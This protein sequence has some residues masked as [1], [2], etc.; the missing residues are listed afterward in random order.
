M[1]NIPHGVLNGTY[2]CVRHRAVACQ[3][4]KFHGV[5]ITP[6]V[7]FNNAHQGRFADDAGGRF[8]ADVAQFLNQRPRTQAP[9]FLV[10]GEGKM[11]RLGKGKGSIVFGHGQAGCNEPLH[12][13]GAAAKQPALVLVHAERVVMSSPGL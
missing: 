10:M 3:T 8:H 7:T 5:F 11:H 1:A 12:V 13:A 2:A 9:G 4:R 6:L